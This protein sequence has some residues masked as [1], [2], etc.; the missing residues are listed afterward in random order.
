MTVVPGYCYFTYILPRV[1]QPE[2]LWFGSILGA[3]QTVLAMAIVVT[4]VLASFVNP[5]I[6]WVRLVLSGSV[7]FGT[8]CSQMG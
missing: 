3:M 7:E 5:G 4:F 1:L 8:P 6:V 2:E